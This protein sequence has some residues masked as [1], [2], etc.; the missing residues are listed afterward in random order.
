M[1]IEKTE[2][3]TVETLGRCGWYSMGYFHSLEDAKDQK[4]I[5]LENTNRLDVRIVKTTTICE[6]IEL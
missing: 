4:K 2:A 3:F 5:I 1:I 6:V